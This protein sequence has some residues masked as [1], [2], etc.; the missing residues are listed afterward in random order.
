MR[1]G[2]GVISAIRSH[3]FQKKFPVYQNSAEKGLSEIG[4]RE[5]EKT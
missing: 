1:T 2:A 5:G 4:R 3:I